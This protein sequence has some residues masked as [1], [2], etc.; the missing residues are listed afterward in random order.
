[1]THR[2]LAHDP[3]KPRPCPTEA[4]PGE[5]SRIIP[6]SFVALFPSLLCY[7]RCCYRG[8]GQRGASTL[9]LSIS[10][11]PLFILF[12]VESVT[13]FALSI[14]GFV[15]LG[16]ARISPRQHVASCILDYGNFLFPIL[17]RQRS[18]NGRKLE[19]RKIILLL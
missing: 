6:Q 8:F 15:V 9:W 14:L 19:V 17:T 12:C 1:M 18:R 16:A 5:L 13:G 10:K 4:C 7:P 3:L 11:Q 2:N